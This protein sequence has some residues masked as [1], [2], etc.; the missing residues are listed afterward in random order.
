MST[1]PA[2]F[3][4]AEPMTTDNVLFTPKDAEANVL[5]ELGSQAETLSLGNRTL[6]LIFT[7][8]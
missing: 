7:S 6:S 3:K 8:V 1:T 4:I 2:S 5:R